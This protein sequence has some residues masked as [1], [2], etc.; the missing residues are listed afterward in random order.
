MDLADI[1]AIPALVA[2]VAL[3]TYIVIEFSRHAAALMP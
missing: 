2:A 1:L 3:G